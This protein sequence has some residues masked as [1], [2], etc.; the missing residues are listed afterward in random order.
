MEGY[1]GQI[2]I[3]AGPYAPVG[4]AFCDG[5]VLKIQ[6]Y[7]ALYSLFTTTYGGDGTTTFGLPDLR[8]RLPVHCESGSELWKLGKPVG[9][10][11][12][13][14]DLSQMAVHNH[15][16]QASSGTRNSRTVAT[17]MIC[18]TSPISFYKQHPSAPDKETALSSETVR[19]VGNGKSHTNLMPYLC[20]NFIVCLNGTYPPRS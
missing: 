6:K 9:R 8:G 12:T 16:L 10:E 14:L 11:R 5:Q 1:T 15:L 4:W 3:F 17:N 18:N 13:G 7:P 20:V 19:S 2:K